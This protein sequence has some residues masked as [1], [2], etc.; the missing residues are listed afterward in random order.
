[1]RAFRETL[2][3]PPFIADCGWEPFRMPNTVVMALTTAAGELSDVQAE[4]VG[5]EPTRGVESAEGL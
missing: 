1:M 3:A 2:F 4:A 5:G